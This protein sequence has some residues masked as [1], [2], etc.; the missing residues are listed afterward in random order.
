MNDSDSG[1]L[2]G[3]CDLT[4]WRG[5]KLLL[6]AVSFNVNSGELV[7][8]H[9]TNGT[10]KTTLLRAI[11]G[12]AEFDEG[13]VY[14]K[15]QLIHRAREDMYSDL[16]YLG[17]KSGISAALSPVENLLALCPE[18]SRDCR[19]QI[20]AALA[21]LAIADRI[22]LPCAALS[23]GQQR[24]VSLARLRLQQARL[25]VLDE[26]LTSLD[27]DGY[28]WVR[29][30]ILRHVEHGGAVLFTTHQAIQ[31]GDKP[32]KSVMLGDLS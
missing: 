22:D 30:E 14:W 3:V 27:A 19:S 24:R 20:K 10:G 5:D 15:G 16:L 28:H 12:M 32:V 13:E 11:V 26:P 21:E 2:L 1:A 23:A 7:Q 25:W 6:D 29:Q 4:V 9:G 8:I 31:F 17:H 18:L